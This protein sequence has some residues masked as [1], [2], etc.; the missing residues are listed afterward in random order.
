MILSRLLSYFRAVK[1]LAEIRSISSIYF[2][3]PKMIKITKIIDE[4]V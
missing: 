4:N 2:N 3:D 1:K